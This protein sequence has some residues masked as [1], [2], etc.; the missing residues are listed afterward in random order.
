MT[1]RVAIIGA[2][3]AG[4]TSARRLL[5]KNVEVVLIDKGRHGGGRMC[6]RAVKQPDGRTAKFDLGPPLLYHRL[7]ADRDTP[8]HRVTDLA[9][10]L[11]GGDLFHAC[12]VMRVGGAGEV[13][14]DYNAVRGLAAQGGMRE[15]AFR[16]LGVPNDAL[17]FHDH[18]VAEQLE[19]TES[20]WRVHLR[21]LRDGAESVQTSNVL[22]VTSPVPQA[23]E[24]LQR[25]KID[26]PEELRYA[27]REVRY[28]RCVALYGVFGGGDVTQPGGVWFGDGPFEWIADNH[29]K[30]VSDV[31]HSVTAHT[32]HQWAEEHWDEP[33]A[34]VLDQLL[35]R[36]RP[37]VGDPVGPVG[38]QRWRNARPENPVAAQCAVLRDL[39]TV[40]AGDGFYGAIPDPADAAVASGEAAAARIDGLLTQLARTD[41][42][43]SV[44]RPRRYTLEIGV[45]TLAEA[46]TAIG[47]GADRLELSSALELGGLTPSMGLFDAVRERAGPVPVFVMIRPRPGGFVYA[48]SELAVMEDDIQA[49][50]ANGAAGVV[51]GALTRD[52]RVDREA[53]A[54]LLRFA[55]NR[56]VFHRAFDLIDNQAEALEELIEFGFLR[57]LTGGGRRPAE[58]GPASLAALVQHAGWQIE[59]LPAGDVRPHNVAELVARTRCDQVHSSARAPRADPDP[60][61]ALPG[62]V[63]AARGGRDELRE[64]L[65]AGLRRQLDR[66]NEGDD[67]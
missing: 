59:V 34:Q 43:Y 52:R 8:W 51:F 54:R 30:G 26:L 38:V 7:R 44:A 21:S 65:V 11:P 41:D 10:A 31:P 48:P 58:A 5:Q 39:A 22:L 62:R 13:L 29:R 1:P 61:L 36:L 18:T 45:T 37:W 28:S 15:L 53:C 25:S 67:E 16:L 50:L 32:R 55:D 23:L 4:L 63:V 27:L 57:V 49:L 2:G 47:A 60:A 24:L 56:A 46:G 3:L 14:S 33:D 19:R 20:G 12:G 40:I 66:L 64:E 35:P 9:A 6:T 17:T 42:R